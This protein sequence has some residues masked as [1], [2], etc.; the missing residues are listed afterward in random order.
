MNKN[1]WWLE[2]Q[3]W[4]AN[5]DSV[6][7]SH[8]EFIQ[9]QKKEE[10]SNFYGLDIKSIDGVYHPIEGSSTHFIGDA[11]FS[12]LQP[13]TS[14]LEIGCG[15]G[16]ISCVAAKLGASR[17]IA[18]DIGKGAYQCAQSNIRNLELHNQVE[19]IESNL[20]D[21]VPDE[22]FDYIIFNAPLLHCEPLPLEKKEYNE[23]AIDHEGVVM[24]NF[25]QSAKPYLKKNGQLF[26]T[27]SNIG[28]R[29]VIEEATKML[30]EIGVVNAASAMYR[31]SGNQWRFVL[32]VS[33]Q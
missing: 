18:T 29:T 2:D 19:V 3:F 11:L 17:I 22:M 28:K 23:I 20:F 32:S 7:M 1:W 26:L 13:H 24:L 25:I 10:T 6:M 4:L 12:V 5:M 14:L 16:A 9:K 8:L 15:T 27:I 21:N 31:Q 30:S 33:G